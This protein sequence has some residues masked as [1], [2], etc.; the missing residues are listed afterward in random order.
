M[1]VQVDFTHD[2]RLSA[3]L[4]RLVASQSEA[5]LIVIFKSRLGGDQISAESYS[6]MKTGVVTQEEDC[7]TWRKRA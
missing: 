2:P 6:T 7:S 4:I 5:I 3:E 1:V